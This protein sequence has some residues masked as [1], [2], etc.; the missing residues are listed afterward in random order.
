MIPITKIQMVRD[1]T[2]KTSVR[3]VTDSAKAAQIAA[4]FIEVRITDRE[5]FVVLCLNAKNAVCQINCVSV[6]TVNASLV[7]PR[8][9]FKAAILANASAIIVAHNHPSGV[10]DPS[11]E[12]RKVTEGLAKAGALL[13]IPLLDHVIVGIDLADNLCWYSFKDAGAI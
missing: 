6:G 3:N 9:V 2:L 10:P 8:E 4:D 5:Q 7:H 12:D 11:A 13:G 1:G